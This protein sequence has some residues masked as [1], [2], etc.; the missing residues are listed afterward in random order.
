MGHIDD[1]ADLKRFGSRTWGILDLYYASQAHANNGRVGIDWQI[2][3]V[4][5]VSGAYVIEEYA[6]DQKRSPGQEY[7]PA[8]SSPF[9]LQSALIY[10]TQLGRLTLVPFGEQARQWPSDQNL[11]LSTEKWTGVGRLLNYGHD[12]PPGR[13]HLN[14]DLRIRQ[15]SDCRRYGDLR[16][17]SRASPF[18][19]RSYRSSNARSPI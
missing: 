7:S 19:L 10:F 3:E 17:N 5:E 18:M 4:A 13:V 11:C 9:K 12:F 15:R 14:L 8:L 2:T 6:L 1:P 16:A